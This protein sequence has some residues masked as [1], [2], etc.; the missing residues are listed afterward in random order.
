M[1][2]DRPIHEKVPLLGHLRAGLRRTFFGAA[3]AAARTDD[4]RRAARLAL[5][6]LA[7][8]PETLDELEW[9]APLPYADLGHAK[10]GTPRGAGVVFVTGRFRSGSTLLWQIF[11]GLPG[12][13]AYYEPF[14]ERRWF[15]PAT[16]GSGVDPTHRGV[17]DYGREYRNLTGLRELYK[18]EWIDRRLH[19]EAD[20]WQPEMRTYLDALIAAAPGRAVLQFNRMDFRLP[21]LRSQY[22]DAALVHLY[23][24]PRDQ[25]VSCLRPPE[26]FPASARMADFVPHDRFYLLPWANDLKYTFPFLEP[27]RFDHPYELF[28]AVWSLS[29]RFGRRWADRSLAFESLVSDPHGQLTGLFQALHLDADA[30]AAAAIVD[31]PAP[32]RWKDYA[33]A[34]WFAERETRVEDELL[35]ILGPRG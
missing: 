12:I 26:S 4:G 1:S 6:E 33:P 28:Y 34:A 7:R 24:H 25:W 27:R 21:W 22:P 14:N 20:A 2:S 32:G 18:P 10:D 31:A 13:T 15:D 8:R 30:D 3:E 11:R 5:P 23:R 29:W 35:G 9:D 16:R 17:E 19:L